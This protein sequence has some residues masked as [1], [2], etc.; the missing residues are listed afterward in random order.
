MPRAGEIKKGVAVEYDG[1]VYLVRDIERSVPQG[2]AGG[3][4]YRMRMYD[5]V[6]NAKLDE[7]FKDTD[8][9]NYADL[10]RRPVMFSY[11]DGDEYVFMDTEDYTQYSLNRA[12]IDDELMFV[13]EETQ[14]LQIVLVG[15]KPVTLD[16]PSTVELVIT[17][18]D[19][20]VKGGSATARTKPATLSTGLV[21][22][23]PEHISSGDRIVVNVE[24]RK[25]LRRA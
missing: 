20:S 24:E 23:V 12:P 22:Q 7:T 19:P 21:V 17:E 18:T 13:S 2:R 1:K 10:T 3:S 6:T 8:M 14:G 16:L 11:A 9:L 4:L 15:E 5:V 25:F